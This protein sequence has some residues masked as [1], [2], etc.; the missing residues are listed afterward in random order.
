M[1]AQ[2]MR[3]APAVPLN[4]LVVKLIRDNVL[5]EGRILGVPRGSYGTLE[6]GRMS[7]QYCVSFIKSVVF[8]GIGVHI[9]C[10]D[11]SASLYR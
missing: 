7:P 8:A 2:C 5:C 11:Q 6:V 3:P 10:I 1:A 9:S 4:P